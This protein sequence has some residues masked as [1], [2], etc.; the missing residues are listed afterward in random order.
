MRNSRLIGWC[1]ATREPAH[2]LTNRAVLALR[3]K[4]D[5]THMQV[6]A[7][8]MAALALAGQPSVEVLHPFRHPRSLL[9][10]FVIAEKL[11]KA[12]VRAVWHPAWFVPSPRLVMHLLGAHEGGLT[13]VEVR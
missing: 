12:A 9:A 13:A 7:V 10:D 6:A 5:G 2:G 4:P 1:C 8:G 3:P 11:L